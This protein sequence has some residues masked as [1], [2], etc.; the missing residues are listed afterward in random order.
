MAVDVR[1]RESYVVVM[2]HRADPVA[3]AEEVLGVTL[4]HDQADILRALVDNGRVVVRSCFGAG[5]TFLAAVAVLWFL[6]CFKPSTVVTTAPTGRQVAEI[7][8]REIAGRFRGAKYPLE[9]TLLTTKLELD[10]D[11]FAIGLST[12]QPEAFQGFHNRNVL[13]VVDE[14][15]GVPEEI[16]ASVENPLSAGHTRELLIG[17]P[18]Q[19][20][21]TFRDAFKDKG[22]YKT[23]HLS[24]F[25]TPNFQGIS[26]K[27]IADGSWEKKT[28]KL[29]YPSLVT[30]E[31]VAGRYRTWGPGSFL[32]QVRVQGEFTQ[33]GVNNLFAL[34]DVEAAM[35][36]EVEASGAKVMALDVARY[37]DD[38]TAL[39]MRQGNKVVG[40]ETWSHQ[41]S[42][43]TAGRYKRYAAAFK[44]VVAR[45]DSVGVGA[46]VVD[47]L[48]SQ[49][50]R[51]E[52]VNVGTP[53]V[54]TEQFGNLRAEGYWSLKEMMGKIGLPKD[55]ELKSQLCDLRYNYDVKGRLWIEK[56]EDARARGSKSPDIAD[57]LMMAFL[58]VGETEEGAQVMD[59]RQ[60]ANREYAMVSSLRGR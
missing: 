18:T 5:K 48:K 39:C 53:A 46:G 29:A 35:G 55:E 14:A 31:W 11:W 50:F 33:S 2:R 45:V 21:G 52:E 24:A 19:Q 43:F 4:W 6:Y 30:P 57:A 54:D 28:K 51:A 49:G 20:T 25:D 22:G 8:W 38:D 15:S 27:D 13:V 59:L 42:V 44:P 41:D 60:T 32:Y 1:E 40:I 56:K 7:L 17:N 23:F 16:Y 9:G 34:G 12:D 47:I 10:K 58:P 3:W 37:G 36:R 26:E